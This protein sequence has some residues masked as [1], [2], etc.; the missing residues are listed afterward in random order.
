MRIIYSLL[1]SFML[2]FANEI[3]DNF[4]DCNEIFQARKAE[5]LLELERLDEAKQSLSS[6]RSATEDLLDKREKKLTQ[7]E[8]TVANRL[9]KAED[10]EKNVKDLLA[11]N[12]QIL[13]EIKELKMDKISQSYSKMKPQDAANI[14]S[15]MSQSEAVAI[16]SA[17]K[18]D[19]IAKILAKMQPSIAS[20]ITTMLSK[21][22]ENVT[23]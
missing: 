4:F 16:L 11:K 5:L 9:K 14:L 7:D 1:L 22:D 21:S 15:A 8:I 13:A 3:N 12:E 20:T 6:L 18:S 17:L 19:S 2:L 10:L 23:K